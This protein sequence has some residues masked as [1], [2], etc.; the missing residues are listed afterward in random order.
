MLV[1]WARSN[2][3]NV[4]KVLWACEE[5]SLPYERKEAGGPFG[6]VN[7][8]EYRKLNPN[9]LIPTIVD[10]GFVLWESHAIIRYLGEQHGA[11]SL[12]P[13]DRRTRALADQWMVWTN[14]VMWP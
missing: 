8:P 3:V 12:F 10:D 6:V 4:Q 7:T 1:I 11:G 13:S 14:T 9:G 2:S 5:L